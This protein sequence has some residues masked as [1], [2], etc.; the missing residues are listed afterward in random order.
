VC[1]SAHQTRAPGAHLP[2]RS[3]ATPILRRRATPMM[4]LSSAAPRTE[5]ESFLA[6]DRR[7]PYASVLFGAVVLA[8]VASAV[9]ML[10][11]QA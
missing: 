9:V 4:S 3:V 10:I 11:G 2:L 1:A 5:V 7:F 6:Q 8:N